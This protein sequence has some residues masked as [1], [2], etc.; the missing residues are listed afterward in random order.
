MATTN[1]AEPAAPAGAAPAGAAPAGAAQRRAGHSPSLASAV[2]TVGLLFLAGLV[3]SEEPA[4]TRPGD[5]PMFGGTPG[6]NMVNTL[7]KNLPASW[8]VEKG[9]LKNIKW[10]AQAGNKIYGGPVIAGGKVFIGTNNAFPRDTAVKGKKAVVMCFSEADGK[11]LWQIA[12][13]IPNNQIFKEATEQGL[14]STPA[15]DG[16]RIYYVTPSC[17]LI[18]ADTADG[19][20]KWS[21]DM[22][23]KLDVVPFHLGNCSPLVIGDLVYAVT[24]NAR[25]DGGQVPAPKAPSFVAVNKTSGEVVWKSNLPG[26]ALIEGQWSNP[27]YAE[28]DG[29]GQVIF[30]GGDAVL[31]SFEPKTGTLI[32]KFDCN[33]GK[34]DPNAGNRKISNYIVSTPVIHDK[35]LYVGLGLYPE[36]PAP[37]SKFSYV[38]CLDI[39]KKGDVS[40]RSLSG[41]NDGKSALIWAYGGPIDPQPKEGRLYEFGRTLST[42][43]VQGGLVYISEEAGYLH[44]LDAKTGKK[45]WDH[46]F[47][48]PIWGSPY[49]VDGKVYIGTDDGELFI[50]A[51]GK[52]KKLLEKINMDEQMQSTPVAANGTL[53]VATRSTVYAIGKKVQ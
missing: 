34:P 2:G 49:W 40:A 43:A 31:Y 23:K 22:M 4:G 53:Y 30:P 37:D 17:E 45:Q 9:E 52:D 24:S 6:R 21:L 46:D 27:C 8:A 48:S 28:I 44:C 26:L 50:F 51:H 33:P 32:W 41:K 29:K 20:I 3:I 1:A 38:L 25:D 14:C 18:C 13:D 47:L 7:V 5:W 15:V 19:K 10:M 35:R 36:H 11:F 16:N 39:T 42:A 12:H